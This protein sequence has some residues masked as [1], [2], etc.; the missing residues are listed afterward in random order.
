MARSSS[1][2]APPVAAAP[3]LDRRAFDPD[4]VFWSLTGLLVLLD[5]WTKWMAQSGHPWLAAL[6][7]GALSFPLRYNPGVA[8]SLRVEGLDAHAASERWLYVA[9]LTWVLVFLYALHRR[10]AHASPTSMVGLALMHGGGAGN[11]LDRLRHE[12]GVVDFIHVDA[13][14]LAGLVFNVADVAA[15]CGGLLL[16]WALAR[17]ECAPDRLRALA[18]VRRRE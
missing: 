11:L 5:A 10:V 2:T 3:T 6:G 8:F 13:G 16:L 7:Q 12:R 18:L 4:R 17:R 9:T 1:R 14:A 15:L